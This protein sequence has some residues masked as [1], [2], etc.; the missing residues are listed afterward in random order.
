MISGNTGSRVRSEGGTE[1][2][3]FHSPSTGGG[4]GQAN[5]D[6]GGALSTFAPPPHAA[7]EQITPSRTPAVQSRQVTARPRARRR[8]GA[9]RR[10][11]RRRKGGSS[12]A[13]A[14]AR[15]AKSR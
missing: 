13:G 4:S 1:V 9:L 12:P 3:R 11:R 6:A 2:I 10:E 14:G 15:T 7:A 5:T 8:R